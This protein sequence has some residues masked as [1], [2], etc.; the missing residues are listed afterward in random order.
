MITL[1]AP[2]DRSEA[3]AAALRLYEHAIGIGAKVRYIAYGKRENNVHP[4]WDRHVISRTNATMVT[5]AAVKSTAVVHFGCSPKLLEEAKRAD[6]DEKKP[7]QILV[8]IWHQHNRFDAVSM[9]KFD[10]I[11]CGSELQCLAVTNLLHRDMFLEPPVTWCNWDTGRQPWRQEGTRTDGRM[12]ALLHC[13]SACVNFSAAFVTEMT[14]Q[15]LAHCTNLDIT[16]TYIKSWAKRDYRAWSV[17]R[18]RW[19]PSR[20]SFQRIQNLHQLDL[21]IPQHDWTI[22]PSI[23]SNFGIIAANALACGT[24]VICNDVPPLCDIV[25]ATCGILV[26]CEI[27]ENWLSTPVAVPQL[28]AW[29][30]T[31]ILALRNRESLLQLQC[32]DWNIDVRAALF[33]ALWNDLL[34]L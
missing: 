10:H 12:R 4:K 2:Y 24:P 31:C 6:L 22:L 3:T 9:R 7:K 14:S 23:K 15:L 20:L 18:K 21:L 25:S 28:A 17:P 16:L 19:A 27:R 33:A 13:D 11:V 34:L 5:N 26:P 32:Q 1:L 8:P 29:V 30:E